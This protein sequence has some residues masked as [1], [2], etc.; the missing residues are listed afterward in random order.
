MI[1]LKRICQQVEEALILA[2]AVFV[3]SGFIVVLAHFFSAAG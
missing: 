1:Y 2:S 3:V